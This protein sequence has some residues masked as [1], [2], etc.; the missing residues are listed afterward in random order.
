MAH[1]SFPSPVST[2]IS[3]GQ[4]LIKA[5]LFVPHSDTSLSVRS[6]EPGAFCKDISPKA[7]RTSFVFGS[8][9]FWLPRRSRSTVQNFFSAVG[10]GEDA[11]LPNSEEK[12][13]LDFVFLAEDSSLDF[14]LLNPKPLFF[15]AWNAD[16]AAVL[17]SSSPELR[18]SRSRS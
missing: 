4:P 17:L 3:L 12:N 10:A 6:H 18:L 7:S 1:N 15:L 8:N 16:T 9:S 14:E 2:E 11:V 13:P 5:S